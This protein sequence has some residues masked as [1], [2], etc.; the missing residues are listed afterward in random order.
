MEAWRQPDPSGRRV[1][2]VPWFRDASCGR[3]GRACRVAHVL[4]RINSGRL[5]ARWLG[6][7]GAMS[8]NRRMPTL[9]LEHVACNVADPPAMA[10]WYVEHL[11]MRIVRQSSDP[12]QIHF[13]A[14]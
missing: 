12:P 3:S 14:D 4:D 2:R 6:D 7:R 13:L 9:N 1:A 11:G 5:R 10:A 8:E